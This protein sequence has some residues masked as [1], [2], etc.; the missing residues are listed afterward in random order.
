MP[1][2]QIAQSSGLCRI[3]MGFC[4]LRNHKQRNQT[5]IYPTLFANISEMENWTIRST[6]RHTLKCN[7][8]TYVENYLEGYHIPYLHP[9]LTKEISMSTYQ[10]IIRER[11]MEHRVDTKEGTTSEGYWAYCW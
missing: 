11:E 8:K 1:R 9:S 2:P 3:R 10:V 5:D 6:Q 7:W 4:G